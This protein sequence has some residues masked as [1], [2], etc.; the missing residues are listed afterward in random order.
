MLSIP[1]ERMEEVHEAMLNSIGYRMITEEPALFAALRRVNEAT[2]WQWINANVHAPGERV[3]PYVGPEAFEV[4]RDLV[5]RGMDAGA[6]D[7]YRTSQIAAW[8]WWMDA[9]FRVTDDHDE[10]RE[11]L[12]VTADS[13]AVYI[14]DVIEAVA[15]QVDAEREELTS[16][17]HAERIAAVTL[18]LEG[19]PI[20][21][22]RAESQLGYPLTGDHTAAI[23]WTEAPL[24]TQLSPGEPSSQLDRAAD[25]LMQASGARR[26][27]VVVPSSTSLWVWLPTANAPAAERVEAAIADAPDVRVAIGRPGSDLDGF[28]RSHLDATTTHRLL[29]RLR[30]SSR[31]AQFQDVQLASLLTTDLAGA[32]QFLADVL[33][34]LVTADEEIRHTV[35][36]FIR[37]QF[38]TSRTAEKLFAHRNTIV[39]RLTRADELLPRPLT[40]NIVGVAA[41]LDLIALRGT[42]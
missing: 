21:R 3:A 31:V 11:L 41:A 16:G 34:D 37:E 38:N 22:A 13:I 9:C 26:R 2:V 28:R 10:L 25:V 14:D 42:L 5:R 33:G 23:I 32:D 7:S 18:L 35:T 15:L 29:S 6:L 17:T 19:A 24:T 4:G 12:D 39:R 40:D 20:S 30:S 8:R 1:P 27:L 36:T